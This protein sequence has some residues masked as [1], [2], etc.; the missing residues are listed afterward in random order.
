VVGEDGELQARRDEPVAQRRLHELE[1]LVGVP[2][3]PQAREVVRRPLALGARRPGDDGP[4]ARAHLLLELGLGLLQAARGRVGALGAQLD[5]LVGDD[6]GQSVPRAGVDR[7]ADDVRAD[8][9]RVRVGVVE[10]GR[11]VLPV[12]AQRGREVLL[13]GDEHVGVRGEVEE[14]MEPVDRQQLGHVGTLV[15][16]VAGGDLRELAVL[17][18]QL[19]RGR[20]LDDV[21]VAE[22]ALGERRELAQA[23]DL[24]VEQLDA[25]GT[26]ARRREQVEDVAAQGELPA[27]LDLVDALVA[28]RRELGRRLGEVEQ[29]AGAD[30]EAVGAQ[31][32]VGHLLGQR[33]GGDDDDGRLDTLGGLVEQRVERR[34]AQ[35][36]Q[37]GRRREVRLVGD[38]AARVDADRPRGEPRAQVGGEVA[39][40]AVVAGDDERRPRRAVGQRRDDERA[41]RPGHERAAAVAHE[42]GGLRVVVEVVE[43]VA[44]RHGDAERPRRELRGRHGPPSLGRVSPGRGARR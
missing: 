7:G 1:R 18:G 26:L 9:E 2:R 14:R 21:D 32:R 28:H 12:V 15:G 43:E 30:R 11:H 34:D 37:V 31:R 29:V 4:V 20:D 41:Q 8:V 3:R 40:L 13:G 38:A 22:R 33:D 16:V 23:L 17:G 42:R 5:G 35:A 44:Q 27:V 6:R 25:D 36:D 39:G 19:G 10:G 24:D